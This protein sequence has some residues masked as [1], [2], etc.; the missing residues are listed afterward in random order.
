MDPVCS[1]RY[2]SRIHLRQRKNM[3]LEHVFS[4]ALVN[5]TFLEVMIGPYRFSYV[6]RCTTSQNSLH[7]LCSESKVVQ[8]VPLW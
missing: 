4:F 3:N 6:T 1:T 2:G 5:D 7:K 8:G